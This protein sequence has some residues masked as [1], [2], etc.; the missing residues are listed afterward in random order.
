[1]VYIYYT[2]SQG[3]DL[4][5]RLARLTANGDV[6]QSGSLDDLVDFPSIGDAVFHMGGALHFGPDGKIYVAL[7]DHEYFDGAKLQT[8][9]VPFGKILRFNSSGTIPS[10]NPFY[11]Q[12]SDVNGATYVM[13]LR[14]PFTFN[15]QPGTGRMFINDVGQEQWE[16][17]DEGKAG[18]NYGWPVSEGP[19]NVGSFTG[20]IYYYS[21]NEGVAITG[22]VF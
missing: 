1:F 16:E 15:F 11:S 17:I 22:S 2:S 7:G 4:H 19:D 9:E 20:P 5:N 18:K 14:N 6:A 21:H 12:A 13:G 10:D 8:L 3:G